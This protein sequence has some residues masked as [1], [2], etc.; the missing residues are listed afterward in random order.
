MFYR[1]MRRIA[2]MLLKVFFRM[3]V[4]GGEHVPIQGSLVVVANHESFLDPFVMGTALMKRR[5]SFLAAPWLFTNK[6]TGWFVRGVGA[7]Q[8]YG[9][10]LKI[11]LELAQSLPE[12]PEFR[13]ELA[14]THE[15]LVSLFEDVG[16]SDNV[17]EHRR[18]AGELPWRSTPVRDPQQSSRDHL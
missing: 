12:L 15:D 2:W 6:V 13:E 3:K 4:T 10:G 7:L 8:A 5:V 1:A 17:E 16:Q 18:Q 11:Q 9:D 14:N